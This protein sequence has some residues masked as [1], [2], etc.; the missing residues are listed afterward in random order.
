MELA[1][2]EL[3]PKKN[4]TKRKLSQNR[5]DELLQL[6]NQV[7]EISR[8]AP[9]YLITHYIAAAESIDR[10]ILEEAKIQKSTM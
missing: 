5:V 3:I 8:T 4:L 1:R 2:K 10:L 6:L 7:A 9:G